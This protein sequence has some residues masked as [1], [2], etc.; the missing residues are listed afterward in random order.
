[1]V[2]DF[3]ALYRDPVYSVV[4]GKLQLLTTCIYNVYFLALYNSTEVKGNIFTIGMLFSASEVLG[5]MVVEPILS[6]VSKKKALVACSILSIIT[7]VVV[8][9]EGVPQMVRYIIF[10]FQVCLVGMMFNLLFI[11]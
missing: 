8:K 1:M 4:Q 11:I 6:Q 5:V 10:L 3:K 9:L 2:G 7:A